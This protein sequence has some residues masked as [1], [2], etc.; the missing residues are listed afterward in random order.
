[1]MR[2]MRMMR[3]MRVKMMRAKWGIGIGCDSSARG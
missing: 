3:V 2:A 1:M